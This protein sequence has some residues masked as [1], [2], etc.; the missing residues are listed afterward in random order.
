[1]DEINFVKNNVVS[2]KT[3][4]EDMK[5]DIRKLQDKT[6]IHDRE[7]REIKSDLKEIKEDTKWLRRAI[8]NAFIAALIVGAVA[9]F[10]AAINFN[11]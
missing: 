10:Y 11:Q 1:M 6:L 7:I 5:Q 3:S 4:V 2:I 9:I 8:T